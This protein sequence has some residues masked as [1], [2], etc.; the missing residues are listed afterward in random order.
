M[1][2]VVLPEDERNSTMCSAVLTRY[3]SV[4]DRQT[5]SWRGRTSDRRKVIGGLWRTVAELCG[6]S[7]CM[8]RC[9]LGRLQ[10]RQST[11]LNYC[12]WHFTGRLQYT[13]FINRPRRFVYHN[14]HQHH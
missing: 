10:R 5:N 6:V 9:T 12:C 14:R 1:A 2:V 3:R 11:R 13:Q 8:E 4:S 7:V